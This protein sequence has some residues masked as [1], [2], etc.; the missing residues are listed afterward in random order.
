MARPP[1][2]RRFGSGGGG[3]QE[4]ATRAARPRRSRRPCAPLR[5]SASRVPGGLP[6][7]QIATPG[8]WGSASRATSPWPR[9]SATGSGFSWP[10]VR[11]SN[12][13]GSSY[14]NSSSFIAESQ[15]QPRPFRGELRQRDREA[16]LID[17]EVRSHANGVAPAVIE[18]QERLPLFEPLVPPELW[19]SLPGEEDGL[20]GAQRLGEERRG[21]RHRS[22]GEP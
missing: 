2:V 5:R 16:A 8:S 11:I 22:A 15:Q 14:S 21:D 4:R 10:A 13:P 12:S 19:K 17:I 7:T 1:W 3:A 18:R 20:S 6:S 9:A